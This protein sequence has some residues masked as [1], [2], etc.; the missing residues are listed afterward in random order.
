M[1]YLKKV[2]TTPLTTIAKVINSLDTQTN[3]EY[4]APSIK[5]VR[6]AINNNTFDIY[7]V[8]SIYLSVNDVNPSTLFGGTWQQ[9]KDKF[10]LACGDTYNNGATGGSATNTLA[11]NQLPSHTHTYDKATTTASHT[12]TVNEIPSHNH[13]VP[14]YGFSKAAGSEAGAGVTDNPSLI[15]AYVDTKAVGGGQGHSHNISSFTATNSGGTG[16]GASINNM[17]PYLAVNVWVRT[18]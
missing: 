6:E 18:A 11:V 8:G 3:D 16:S 1:R 2:A 7:P 9:I 17:P 5:A 15:Q 14:T 12:L 10:L 4:N 13:G